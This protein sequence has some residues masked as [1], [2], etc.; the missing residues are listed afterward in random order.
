MVGAV[1]TP[2]SV[3]GMELINGQTTLIGSRGGG[4]IP[5]RDFHS[6][7]RLVDGINDLREGKVAGRAVVVL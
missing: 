5:D 1:R 2:F 3:P 4:C 7:D 6:L